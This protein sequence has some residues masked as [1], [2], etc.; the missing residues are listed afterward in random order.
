M[1]DPKNSPAVQSMEIEQAEQRERA[2]KNDL[3]TGLEDSFPASDPVSATHSAVPAGRTDADEADRV[4]QQSTEEEFPLVDQALRS[5]GE[6]CHSER[7]NDSRDALGALRRDV[8]RMAGTATE[9][10]SGATSLAKSEARTFVK[11][12]EDKI[13]ERPI[14]A[15]AV[16]AALA[17]VFGATR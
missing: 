17:F 12:I 6:G 15:V 3:D 16:V 8:D 4:R 9:V 10:A 5:T 13:R 2:V 1:A 14:A 11:S 7:V